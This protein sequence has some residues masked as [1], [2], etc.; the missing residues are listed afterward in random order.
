MEAILESLRAHLDP[1]A[2]EAIE[3]LNASL[4]ARLDKLTSAV[5]GP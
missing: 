5:Q 4:H 3:A 2:A 1:E